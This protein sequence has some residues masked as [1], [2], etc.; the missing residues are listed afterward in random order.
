VADPLSNDGGITIS[1]DSSKVEEQITIPSQQAI[2]FWDGQEETLL[3]STGIKI[4]EMNDLAWIIPVFSKTKPVVGEADV[5]IFQQVPYLFSEIKIDRT[6][7]ILSPI[8][9]LFILIIL[10]FFIYRIIVYMK[11]KG[12]KGLTK[13]IIVSVLILFSFLLLSI[14]FVSF[15]RVGSSLNAEIKP[16]EVLE[17]KKVGI[18]DLVIL[19]STNVHFMVNWLK[20]NGY[21]VSEKTLPVLE[22]YCKEPNTYFIVNKINQEL[23]IEQDSQEIAMPLKISFQPEKPFYPMKLSSINGGLTNIN[24]FLFADTPLRDESG[25]LSLKK[26]RN[27]GSTLL[28]LDRSRDFEIERASNEL[29]DYLHYNFQPYAL[30][31]TWLQF[32]D[33][34]ALLNED[35]YF[36]FDIELCSFLSEDRF[37]YSQDQ[38]YEILGKK[39]SDIMLCD[40]VSN[41][42]S[43]E[44]CFEAVLQRTRNY[45]LCEQLSTLDKKDECYFEAS[46]I[47]EDIDF[48]LTKIKKQDKKDSCF[49]GLMYSN[50]DCEICE[51]I[52]DSDSRDWCYEECADRTNN[53]SL[54]ARIKSRTPRD[55]CYYWIAGRIKEASLCDLIDS[56]A[57]KHDCYNAVA[58]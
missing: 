49:F 4:A 34:L 12:R 52:K 53:A 40:K 5:E 21:K 51:R 3:L 18:Y 32:Q 8:F 41:E 25:I 54:C 45:S 39:S 15:P 43:R 27:V 2:I 37:E 14:V 42:T 47:A 58:K 38:C 10:S 16:L 6:E 50:H 56:K 46:K 31:A 20:E 1:V 11:R 13:G 48:C 57:K 35:S 23:L 26:A 9:F 7:E 19:K 30:V 22:D 29:Y 28:Y 55:W 33:N 44:E 24:V 36:T 17:V